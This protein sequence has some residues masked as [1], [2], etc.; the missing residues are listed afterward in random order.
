MRN[1]RVIEYPARYLERKLREPRSRVPY[2]EYLPHFAEGSVHTIYFKKAEDA[3]VSRSDLDTSAFPEGWDLHV[4]YY[5]NISVFEAYR[6]NGA[7]LSDAEVDALLALNQGDSFW[8]RVNRREQPQLWGCDF[9]LEDGSMMA[10]RQGNFLIFYRPEFE[11][12]ARKGIE[13]VRAQAREEQ[14]TR[15][16]TSVLGF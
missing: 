8:K 13:E 15:A 5:Q 1:R 7:S 12:I 10:A 2:R 4:V 9:V 14:V 11:E 3:T 6:R 16:P